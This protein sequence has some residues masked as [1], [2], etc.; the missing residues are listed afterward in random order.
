MILCIYGSTNKL[1]V[2]ARTAGGATY[3]RHPDAPQAHVLP[4]YGVRC[5]RYEA[6]AMGISTTSVFFRCEHTY[7]FRK[8]TTWSS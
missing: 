3:R 7:F 2:Q 1:L 6:W 8:S 4:M 5:I